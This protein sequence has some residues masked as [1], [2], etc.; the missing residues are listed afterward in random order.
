[1]PRSSAAEVIVFGVTID[2]VSRLAYV[3]MIAMLPPA[4][5]A[6]TTGSMLAPPIATSSATT[7]CTTFTPESKFCRMT[8]RACCLKNPISWAI[9]TSTLA[10]LV[11]PVGSPILSVAG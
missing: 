7:A 8:S 11:L 4:T 10:K 9:T 5:E 2:T 3:P 6:L 1:M